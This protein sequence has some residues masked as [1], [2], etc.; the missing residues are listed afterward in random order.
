MNTLGALERVCDHMLGAWYLPAIDT[1]DTTDPKNI[2][3]MNSLLASIERDF[4]TQFPD[5]IN[6]IDPAYFD[7][8]TN[9]FDA[10]KKSAADLRPFKGSTPVL[11][12]ES[13]YNAS[14][15]TYEISSVQLRPC[16]W[17]TGLIR[18]LTQHAVEALQRVSGVGLAFNLKRGPDYLV[19]LTMEEQANLFLK[20]PKN[21]DKEIQYLL[22]AAK[23][24]QWK[25][26]YARM[27]PT[28]KAGWGLDRIQSYTR[29]DA[30]KK[31]FES[32]P[33]FVR[34]YLE[35]KNAQKK[36]VI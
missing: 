33:F 8:V 18:Q 23:F 29:F 14:T 17:E 32:I 3:F 11:I 34:Q 9:V 4:S 25:R 15:S 10:F 21:S 26:V 31:K 16:V 5:T 2:A 22:P 7:A 6:G 24:D 30:T 36:T 20:G 1:E 13:A 12:F 28:L 19:V 35:H 27:D